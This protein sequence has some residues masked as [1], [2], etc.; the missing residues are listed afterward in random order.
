MPLSR[1]RRPCPRRRREPTVAAAAQRPTSRWSAQ[2]GKERVGERLRV[3][4]L[5]RVEALA[6]ADELD[7]D[8]GL[9]ADADDDTILGQCAASWVPG[10]TGSL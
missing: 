2:V 8:V 3:D 5:D 4:R 1:G 10:R 6:E 7:R 9:A